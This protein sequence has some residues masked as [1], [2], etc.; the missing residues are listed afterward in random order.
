MTL[1][2]FLEIV[3]LDALLTVGKPS[4]LAPGSPQLKWVRRDALLTSRP[5]RLASPGRIIPR[6]SNRQ[7]TDGDAT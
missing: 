1:F 2:G 4:R 5:S 3:R 6:R 7:D